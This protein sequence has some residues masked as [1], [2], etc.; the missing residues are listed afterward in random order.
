ME[1]SRPR[2]SSTSVRAPSSVAVGDFNGDGKL[3]LGVTSNTYY[4]GGGS[5]YGSYPGGYV[6]RVNVLLGTGGGSFSA[7]I[8][9]YEAGFL[10]AATLADFN[11]DGKLDFATTS[12]DDG[13]VLVL[14]GTGTGTLG[15]PS[16]Y[17]SASGSRSMA[18]GDVNGDGSFDL[19]MGSQFNDSVGVLLGNGLGAFGTTQ[20]L[21]RR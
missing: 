18:A 19:V 7:P 15:T 6:G 3:D 9:S 12:Y 4:P 5:Y 20:Y 10:T 11:G 13:Y 21:R 2:L 16:Y 8:T 1:P 17:N 14:P